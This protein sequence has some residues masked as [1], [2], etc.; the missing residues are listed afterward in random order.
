[1]VVQRA[2]IGFTVAEL[3]VTL[4]ILSLFVGLFYQMFVTGQSQQQF[5][6]QR[7][8]AN[9]V[10]QSNLGK[11]TSKNQIPGSITCNSTNDTLNYPSA[12]GTV[13]ATSAS[14]ASLKWNGDGSPSSGLAKENIS[15]TVLPSSSNQELRVFYPRGCA[16]NMPARIV[17]TV[18]YGSESVSHAT[19]VK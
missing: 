5:I 9:D 16:S 2:D 15:N 14:G 3:V 6:S 11:V 1:M 13:I 10:A 12:P 7:A 19:F 4:V 18:T 17:S 8:V